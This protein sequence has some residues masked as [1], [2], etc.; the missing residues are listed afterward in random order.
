MSFLFLVLTDVDV[1]RYI[2][3]RQTP[4]YPYFPRDRMNCMTYD[5][6]MIYE[7]CGI[8]VPHASFRERKKVK[9]TPTY[10][11][12][13]VLYHDGIVLSHSSKCINA[14]KHLVCARKNEK[15]NQTGRSRPGWSR[16]GRCETTRRPAAR[17]WFV[18]APGSGKPGS[19][20]CS[21][22][23]RCCWSMISGYTWGE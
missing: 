6:R 23:L 8:M 20:C 21:R 15:K 22:G 7:V 14:K 3:A 4:S 2:D 11:V 12:C 9:C 5:V 16:G 17:A 18:C 10:Q 19:W 1:N 13:M